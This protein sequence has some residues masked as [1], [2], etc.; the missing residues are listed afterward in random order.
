LQLAV[1]G[2]QQPYS[3]ANSSNPQKDQTTYQIQRAVNSS[4][5]EKKL[6]NDFFPDFL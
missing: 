3:K 2:I 1:Q 5:V 6:A 4:K